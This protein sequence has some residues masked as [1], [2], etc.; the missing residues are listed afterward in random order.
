MLQSGRSGVR[1]VRA[2]KGPPDA[3]AEFY[4]AATLVLDSRGESVA[5]ADEERALAAAKA[6]RQA[7]RAAEGRRTYPARPHDLDA[8]RDGRCGRGQQQ[9]TRQT[10]TA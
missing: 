5:E 8:E 4:D 3:F 9:R 1:K 7:A 6:E 10:R 2:T